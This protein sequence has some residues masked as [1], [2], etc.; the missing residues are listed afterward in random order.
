MSRCRVEDVLTLR[1]I[2]PHRI[3]WLGNLV[4]DLMTC[5]VLW[6]CILLVPPW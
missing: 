2:G 6:D 3:A 1:Y 4:F 5:R